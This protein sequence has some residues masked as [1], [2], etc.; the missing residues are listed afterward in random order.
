MGEAS[1]ERMG[2]EAVNW[3]VKEHVRGMIAG[4]AGGCLLA[5]G[6]GGQ[7]RTVCSWAR[8]AR[9]CCDGAQR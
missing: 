3:G 1:C 9:R 5:M 6:G 8:A 7:V 2:P 4:G